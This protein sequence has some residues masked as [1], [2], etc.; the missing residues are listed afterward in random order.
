MQPKPDRMA[1]KQIIFSQTAEQKRYKLP[2]KQP[3]N[4][5]TKTQQIT[6]NDL[7][8]SDCDVYSV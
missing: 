3:I 8:F 1:K 4:Y 5:R 2:N 7:I 6:E